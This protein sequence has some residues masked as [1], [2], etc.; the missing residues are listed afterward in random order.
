MTAA[1]VPFAEA[2]CNGVARAVYNSYDPSPLSVSFDW[3]RSLR[4]DHLGFIVPI[5]DMELFL[6]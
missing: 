3:M 2:S 1:A 4:S 5:L 6:L